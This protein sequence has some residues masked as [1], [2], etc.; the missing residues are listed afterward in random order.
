[1]TLPLTYKK[2]NCF[3]NAYINHRN[4]YLDKKLHIVFGSFAINGWFE[5]GGKNWTKK[6][7]IKNMTGT[8]TTDAHCWLE[9]DDGNVYDYIHEGYDFWVKIR[10]NKPMKF[11]GLVEGMSKADLLGKGIEYVPAD[12]ETQ[13]MIFLRVLQHCREAERRLKDGSA[14]WNGNYLAFVL[15]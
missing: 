6:D 13:Q 12:K 1:M 4:H 8:Y 3:I 9:D 14:L 11:S 15:V 10:T 7:F 5:F 2:D